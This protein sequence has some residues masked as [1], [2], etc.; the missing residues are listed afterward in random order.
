[1]DQ[2]SRK[3]G[4]KRPV[5]GMSLAAALCLGLS[6][7]TP[8]ERLRG[9]GFHDR[10]M[11]KAIRETDESPKPSKKPQEFWGFSNKAREIESN[12]SDR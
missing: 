9:E 1:M 6:G 12:F 3:I 2:I 4:W 10:S 11:E 8:L 7:C 5:L